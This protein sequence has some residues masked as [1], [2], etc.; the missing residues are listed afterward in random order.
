MQ[1]LGGDFHEL[2]P[3]GAE[4]SSRMLYPLPYVLCVLCALCVLCVVPV[5]L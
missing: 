4:V 5:L 3:G 1:I 2:I